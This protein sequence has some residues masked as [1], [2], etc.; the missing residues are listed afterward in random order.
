[1]DISRNKFSNA[2]C[3]LFTSVLLV[4]FCVCVGRKF[5]ISN[6][7]SRMIITGVYCGV[8][9]GLAFVLN[10]TVKK[11]VVQQLIPRLLQ[12]KE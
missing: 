10:K 9:V 4:L 6:M 12:M 7:V 11:F 3:V 8:V 2:M 5:G 1:M